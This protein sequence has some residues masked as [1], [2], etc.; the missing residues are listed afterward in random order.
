MLKE[1]HEAEMIKVNQEKQQLMTSLQQTQDCR[2]I[3]QADLTDMREKFIQRCLEA[4]ELH[5]QLK[6]SQDQVTQA[7]MTIE[8][9]RARRA[10]LEK[11]HSDLQSELAKVSTVF[12][13]YF[14]LNFQI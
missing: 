4:D 11:A 5:L 12:Y 7:R 13:Y 3:A 14:T 6:A 8:V 1:K 10:D 2:D 9:E